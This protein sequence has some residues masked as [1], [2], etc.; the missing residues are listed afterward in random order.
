M[1]PPIEKFLGF[2]SQIGSVGSGAAF[3]FGSSY[4]DGAGVFLDDG[5]LG[6]A[7][8]AQTLRCT[9]TS[10]EPR[11]P[12]RTFMHSVKVSSKRFSFNIIHERNPQLG[13]QEPHFN[14]MRSL[15]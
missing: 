1:S 5:A 7:L 11:R 2:F 14:S 10:Q 9:G 12:R 4:G 6:I 15:H 13:T 3:F 8:A